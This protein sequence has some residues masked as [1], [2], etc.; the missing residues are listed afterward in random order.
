MLATGKRERVISKLDSYQSCLISIPIERNNS[1]TIENATEV[2]FGISIR[3]SAEGVPIDLGIIKKT[4]PIKKFS[5]AIGMSQIPKLFQPGRPLNPV[6]SD[7]FQGRDDI[8]NKIKSSF[9]EG[10]QRER[11]FIDGIRRI[12]KTSI[13]NF[14]PLNLPENVIPVLINLDKLGLN[15]TINSAGILFEFCRLICN[16]TS[17]LANVNLELPDEITFNEHPARTF[18]NFLSIFKKELPGKKPF[19]MIDEFQ[20]LLTAIEKTGSG[21]TRD[22]LVLDLLRGYLDEGEINAIFTGSVR[23]DRLSGIIDHRIFGSLTR[24][25]VSFL[26]E[27]GVSSVLKAGIKNWGN[28][29]SETVK[30]VYELTGGYSWLVQ[31]YGSGLVEILNKECRNITTIDDV[32]LITNEMVLSNNELFKFWWPIEQLSNDEERFIELFLRKYSEDHVV[33]TRDFFSNIHS[34]DQA[35]FRRAFDNLRACEV[36][37]STQNEFLKF[38][39]SV[40]RRW[41][42]QQMHEGKLKIRVF[43]QEPNEKKGQAGI[44]IDHENLLKGVETIG[45]NR[46]T[47]MPTQEKEKLDWFNKI[48]TSLLEE[49]EKRVGFLSYKV[50]VAFWDRPQEARLLR[51]Y[52]SHGFSTELPEEMKMENAVDLKVADEV[53]RARERAMREGTNLGRA[54]IVSADGDLSHA[55]R[56][57]VNDGVTVEVWGGSNNISKKYIEIVGAENYVALDDVCGL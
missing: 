15:S 42:E 26:S 30:R 37:E 10:I 54:I 3:A 8:L 57:L 12:G 28:V 17:K 5:E 55:V 38:G 44:F 45:I 51:A 22:T 16:S 21:P 11:Y 9:F 20:V 31:T 34:R 49:A 7:L 41:L 2:V 32:D 24:L 36:L 25:R 56:A 40:L 33:S 48:I 19:L 1:S 43:N 53:R 39:G 6:E 35:T 14:L 46:G 29:T 13:L 52:K 18:D 47:P 50:T 23:F 27:N 4:I